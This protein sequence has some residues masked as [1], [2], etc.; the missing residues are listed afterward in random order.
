MNRRPHVDYPP[1]TARPATD[2]ARSEGAA[3]AR[4]DPRAGGVP[5]KAH[6]VRRCSP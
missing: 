6:G 2:P 1:F 5:V 4:L 3:G